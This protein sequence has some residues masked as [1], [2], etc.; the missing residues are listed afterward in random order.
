MDDKLNQL[1]SE[2]KRL[3]GELAIATFLLDDAVAPGYVGPK[4]FSRI[5]KAY[6]KAEVKF[7]MASEN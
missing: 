1:E 7:N 3:D 4:Y 5:K 6:D 2:V